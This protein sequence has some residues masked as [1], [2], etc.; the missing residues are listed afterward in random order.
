[1]PNVRA[2]DAPGAALEQRDCGSFR[3]PSGFVFLD[4]G[5]VYR[6]VN[7]CYQSHYDHLTSSGLAATLIER[8]LLIRHEEL[9][10]HRVGFD[11]YKLLRADAVP[12][13]SYP[14]EWSFSQLRAAA[15]LT[16]RVQTAALKHGMSL[17]DASAYNVQFVDG[18][19]VFID[20]L[21][22]E[23]YEEGRPWVAY[24]Q[25]CQHFLA[26]LALM[27]Y[28]DVRLS[29]LFRVFLDGVPLDLC[30]Q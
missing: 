3:D 20:T 12:F 8:G 14:Y 25:F 17:K 19:P 7:H 29:Q 13:V 10:S 22:F 15:M 9:P 21:S 30:A 23:L 6:Q 5:V 28:S 1:M 16:L 4:G 2:V 26:P 18:K 24:R 27:A 11:G